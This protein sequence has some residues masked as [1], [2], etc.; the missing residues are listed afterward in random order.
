MSF[1]RTRNNQ[2]VDIH[3][4]RYYPT[5]NRKKAWIAASI[6]L[7]P[8]SIMLSEISQAQEINAVWSH[9]DFYL[10]QHWHCFSQFS[11]KSGM[12]GCYIWNFLALFMKR[13]QY[14]VFCTSI[15]YSCFI[16]VILS[17]SIYFNQKLLKH[18]RRCLLTQVFLVSPFNEMLIR[19]MVLTFMQSVGDIFGDWN[20]S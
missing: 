4:T 11:A 2:N 10:H 17:D 7:E 18:T 5:I 14:H 9:T 16:T 19:G 1:I 15:N 3:A 8:D 13:S 12:V 20:A 6:W